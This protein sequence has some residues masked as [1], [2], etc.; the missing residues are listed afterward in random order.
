MSI[1]CACGYL[2]LQGHLQGLLGPQVPPMSRTSH[3][4]PRSNGMMSPD[5]WNP[6]LL[7]LEQGLHTQLPSPRHLYFLRNTCTAA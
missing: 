4:L 2:Q 6:Q 3:M 7:V 1:P 5:A